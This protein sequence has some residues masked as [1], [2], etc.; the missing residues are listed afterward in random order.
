MT[1]YVLLRLLFNVQVNENLV[2]FL[3]LNETFEGITIH[4]YNQFYAMHFALKENFTNEESHLWL[5]SVVYALINNIHKYPES[6]VGYNRE[7]CLQCIE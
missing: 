1:S 2:L 3:T 6:S 4:L 5:I 7:G